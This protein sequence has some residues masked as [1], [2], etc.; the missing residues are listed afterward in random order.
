MELQKTFFYSCIDDLKLDESST[1][2]GK[3]NDEILSVP[4]LIYDLS[5]ALSF[6]TY[7]GKN[8]DALFDCLCDFHWINERNI[9]I[10]HSRVPSLSAS[11]LNIYIDILKDA[12]LRWTKSNGNDHKLWIV[13]PVISIK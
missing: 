5:S 12:C 4:K 13:M 8:W 3:L 7:F 1:F 10:F 6:P 11:D 9:V 2:I